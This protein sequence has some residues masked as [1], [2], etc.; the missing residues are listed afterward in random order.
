[1][2][3]VG[4]VLRAKWASIRSRHAIAAA[5]DELEYHRRWL[6]HH[7]AAWAE[8]IR[9]YQRRLK[10]KSRGW[11][12]KRL[13][14]GLLLIGPIT[15]LAL[16]R[17]IT[18]LLPW[19]RDPLVRAVGL[20]AL[21]R[22][23][24]KELASHASGF[25]CAIKDRNKP[26]HYARIAGLNGPLCIGQPASS[27]RVTKS[28]TGLLKVRLVIGSFGAVIVGFLAMTSGFD[29][30]S[31]PAGTPPSDFENARSA[32]A[33][34]PAT[35]TPSKHAERLRPD[36]ISGFAVVVPA[37]EAERISLAGATTITE[38]ISQTHP[39][40]LTLEQPE[41]TIDAA[42]VTLPARKPRVRAKRRPTKQN[43]QLTLW[44]R[45]PWLR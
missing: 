19:V 13:A 45:L 11:V 6:D 1:M 4:A 20:H 27:N 42:E 12:L 5:D 41:A 33:L 2:Q 18:G 30:D 35:L 34:S 43:H 9:R 38:I 40:P 29:S 16:L 25:L 10:R 37:P 3:Q 39:L 31:V 21:V 14:L 7:R 17:L 26:R 28:E 32:L 22:L 8:D 44:D 23:A 24:C 15:C 36:P